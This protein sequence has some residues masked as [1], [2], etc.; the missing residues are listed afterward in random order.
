AA[1]GLLFVSAL[2]AFKSAMGATWVIAAIGLMGGAYF[3]VSLFPGWIR[4]GTAVQP[5]TP[6][7]DLLRHLLTGASSPQPAWLDVVKLGGFAVVL[8]PLA[9]AL[10]WQAFRYSRRR[11]TIMEY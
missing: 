5:L 3:P 9:S 4:W 6:A 10:L 7:V 2:I 11:G 1:I 8:M